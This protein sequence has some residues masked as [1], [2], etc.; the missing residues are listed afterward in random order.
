MSP[1]THLFASWLV[2]TGTTRNSRDCRLAALAG[3]L[4]DADGLGL[5]VDVIRG[6]FITG[7]PLLY[8]RYHHFL[9]HGLAGGLLLAGLLAL[10]ARDRLRVAVVVLLVFHLHL[11]CDFAGSRGPAPE[12]VWPVFYCGPFSKDPMWL[13]RGQWRLDGWQNRGVSVALFLIS[14]G[15]AVRRGHSPLGVFH[16]RADAVFVGVLRRWWATWRG[17]FWRSCVGQAAVVWRLRRGP[18][19]W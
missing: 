6:T 19:C 17:R 2:A 18:P 10:F 3:V 14:L 4:P 16:Q 12:D 9:L 15:W 11:L 1:V 8:Q 5:V 7:G 13:W